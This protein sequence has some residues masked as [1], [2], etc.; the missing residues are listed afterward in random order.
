LRR[1]D[2]AVVPY[3]S[4]VIAAS[5]LDAGYTISDMSRWYVDVTIVLA[6][7][8]M[9]CIYA[10]DF[11]VA[12]A[13]MQ[14]CY[15]VAV[16]TCAFRSMPRQCVYINTL[17][18]TG[19]YT[20]HG[21]FACLDYDAGMATWQLILH[22]Y[23]EDAPLSLIIGLD[24]YKTIEESLESGGIQ[25]SGTVLF[26]DIDVNDLARKSIQYVLC[27]CADNLSV[28]YADTPPDIHGRGGRCVMTPNAALKDVQY[29][30]VSGRHNSGMNEHAARVNSQ[31]PCAYVWQWRQLCDGESFQSKRLVL[32]W[33]PT[34]NAH[35][36]PI[37]KYAQIIESRSLS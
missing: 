21:F 34:A 11:A 30:T 16:P 4:D 22:Y 9:P 2:H 25:Y 32:Y 27:L 8:A 19:D 31:D 1:W 12:D 17:V 14:D 26:P 18:E 3:P 28:T 10:F 37:A 5:M 20:F 36:Q 24:E 35:V 7:L 29:G 33:N 15:A 23:E 6:F 13:L